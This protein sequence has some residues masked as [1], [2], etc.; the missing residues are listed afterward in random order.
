MGCAQEQV[1]LNT[2]LVGTNDN[3]SSKYSDNG[4]LMLRNEPL[5]R[6]RD[7]ACQWKYEAV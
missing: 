4:Q 3:D 2:R 6:R 5:T 1:F 7:P